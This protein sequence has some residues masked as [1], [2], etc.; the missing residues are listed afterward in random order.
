MRGIDVRS[1]QGTDLLATKRCICEDRAVAAL[2]VF[3]IAT[4]APRALARPFSPLTRYS[5]AWITAWCSSGLW[6]KLMD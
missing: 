6:D 5:S 4:V 2:V 1:F 3:L